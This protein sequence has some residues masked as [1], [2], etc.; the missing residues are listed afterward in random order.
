[1]AS[2]PFSLKFAAMMFITSNMAFAFPGSESPNT[3]TYAHPG[4]SIQSIIR[5]MANGR[6]TATPNGTRMLIGLS[7]L[8][9]VIAMTNR[10]CKKNRI[11]FNGTAFKF[12]DVYKKSIPTEEGLILWDGVQG[13]IDQYPLRPQI[14]YKKVTE[15]SKINPSHYQVLVSHT[16]GHALFQISESGQLLTAFLGSSVGSTAFADP[17]SGYSYQ[18]SCIPQ[19]N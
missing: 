7:Q 1:M 13:S 5:D 4:E 16:Y 3:S 18:Y 15:P 2:I 12:K 6:G 17:M 10:A 14:E 19:S 11:T 9:E 8:R